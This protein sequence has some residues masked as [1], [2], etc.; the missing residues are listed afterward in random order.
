MLGDC[1]M[2]MFLGDSLICNSL[3]NRLMVTQL[4]DVL[5]HTYL[6]VVSGHTRQVV[7]VSANTEIPTTLF[8]QVIFYNITYLYYLYNMN[9][10]ENNI[11]DNFKYFKPH[12]E[13]CI[14]I[15]I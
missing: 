3:L 12:A 6:A 8:L 4:N 9:C 14:I 15:M 7:N 5:G 2:V 13:E 1:V 10:T 11:L